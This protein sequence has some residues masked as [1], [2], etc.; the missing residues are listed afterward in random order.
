MLEEL[1]RHLSDIAAWSV[2]TGG[3]FVWLRLPD[4][5]DSKELLPSALQARVA[6]V[7]G[8]AFYADGSGGREMRLS[9]CFPTSDRIR[10]GVRRLARVIHEQM[11]LRAALYG[12]TTRGSGS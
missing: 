10:E 8:R 6:Y 2:P 9:F 3:F 7:P 11:A 4:G 1:S 12:E 5:M